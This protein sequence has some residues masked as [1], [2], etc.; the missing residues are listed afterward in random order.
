[1]S[2]VTKFAGGKDILVLFDEM[3]P[4]FIQCHCESIF[5]NILQLQYNM[6]SN[7]WSFE[8]AVLLY[9]IQN[10]NRITLFCF[11]FFLVRSSSGW[12]KYPRSHSCMSS[13]S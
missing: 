8:M 10:V 3:I 12:M 2:V 1:M 7:V 9:S 6:I 4:S 11:V 5:D 13:D